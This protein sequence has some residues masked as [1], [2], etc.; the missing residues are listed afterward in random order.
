MSTDEGKTQIV[1]PLLGLFVGAISGVIHPG[2]FNLLLPTWIIPA[3][4][5]GLLSISPRTRSLAVGFGAA[6]VGWL[7]FSVAFFILGLVAPSFR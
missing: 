1:Q 4:L 5:A 2:M 7:A 6:S 3:L